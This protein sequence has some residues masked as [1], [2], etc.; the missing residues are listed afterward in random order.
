M[1]RFMLYYMYEGKPHTL[2]DLR[3][4]YQLPCGMV[5]PK[6]LGSWRIERQTSPFDA[7]QFNCRAVH[8]IIDDILIDHIHN[9]ADNGRLTALVGLFFYA[10]M[11]LAVKQVVFLLT[12]LANGINF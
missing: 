7:R 9:S 1:M 10:L 5:I 8:C 6:G 12:L 4:Q 2:Q 11:P 3:M